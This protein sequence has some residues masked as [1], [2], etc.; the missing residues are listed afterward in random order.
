MFLADQFSDQPV[1]IIGKSAS[2]VKKCE[3]YLL[4]VPSTPRTPARVVLRSADVSKNRFAA[5]LFCATLAIP[6]LPA[7]EYKT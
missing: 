7:L 5:A 3:H 2:N 6:A 1:R 4:C